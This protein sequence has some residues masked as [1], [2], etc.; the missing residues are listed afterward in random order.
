MSNKKIVLHK[1]PA[2][3][4][5]PSLTS[6]TFRL[7]TVPRPDNKNVP[8]DKVLV[9]VHYLSLDPTMRG[10]LSARRSYIAPVEVG[11]VMR[12]PSMAQVISV[13][14]N[15]AAQFQA[16]DWVYTWAGWQEYAA[17]GVKELEKIPIPPG[18]RPTDVLSTLGVTGLTAYFGLIDVGQPREEDT[19]VVSGA[20]GATGM[21]AGQIAKIKGAKRV[22]GLAGSKDKCDFLVKELGFDVAINYKDA[23]WR[24][25]LKAATPD[26]IDI[27]FDNVGGDILD[28][29]LTR[30]ARNSR[31][32]M[33]GAISQYNSTKPNGPAN[34]MNII[35]QRITMKG[36][37]VFDYA[38]QY[39]QAREELSAWL[40]QGKL[41]RKDHIVPGGL[42]AAPRSLVDLFAGANTGKMMVEVA[43]ASEA[44]APKAKL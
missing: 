2:E 19:V 18:G 29:C 39:Q 44:L 38:K 43:P 10:W 17:L 5:D 6:G 4:I 8:A 16:G 15:L 41:I 1:R 27:Y 20:A 23:D 25:Q 28:M 26:F 21:I 42:E 37:I 35:S 3:G 30:A 14:S 33:C 9:R 24:N 34:Y 31:F 12:G 7:R 11:A 13:G 40:A 32:V 36:F 22:I